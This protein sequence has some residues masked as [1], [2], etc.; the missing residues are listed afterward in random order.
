[1]AVVCFCSSQKARN[2][3]IPQMINHPTS[4]VTTGGRAKF[5]PVNAVQADWYARYNDR[6]YVADLGSSDQVGLLSW[7]SARRTS[8]NQ[9]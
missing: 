8:H 1:M 2:C 5:W 9:R 3:S 4:G 6:I 7:K